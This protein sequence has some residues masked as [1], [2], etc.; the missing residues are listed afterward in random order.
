MLKPFDTTVLGRL[1]EH[2][3][4][5][6]SDIFISRFGNVPDVEFSTWVHMKDEE[7]IVW[8]AKPKKWFGTE[9]KA[10]PFVFL[11]S[12]Y[13]KGSTTSSS[14]SVRPYSNEF[15]EKENSLGFHSL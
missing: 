1:I 4:S 2:R 3:Y 6:R 12:E 13:T 8:V 9:T 5:S 11:L 15:F 14:I 10:P 7:L